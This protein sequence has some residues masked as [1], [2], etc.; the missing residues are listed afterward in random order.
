MSLDYYSSLEKGKTSLMNYSKLKSWRNKQQADNHGNDISHP[1]SGV[2][3]CTLSLE[4]AGWAAPN[5]NL[6]IYCHIRIRGANIAF[7]IMVK[8][9]VEADL[10]APLPEA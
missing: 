1:S 8:E 3:V 7:N 2:R 5:M 4:R 10:T 6:C 9:P